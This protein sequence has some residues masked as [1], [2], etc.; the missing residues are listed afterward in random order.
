MKD[1]KLLPSTLCDDHPMVLYA[2]LIPAENPLAVIAA[3]LLA[4][5]RARLS[6]CA[7]K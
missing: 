4:S 1:S 3:L 5:M 7:R 6:A 2:R